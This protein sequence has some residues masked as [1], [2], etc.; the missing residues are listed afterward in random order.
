MSDSREIKFSGRSFCFTGG[1]ADLKR[2]AAERE[3]RARG[4][5][6]TDAVNDRLDYLVI[7]SI[8]S[9]GWKHGDYGSKIEKARAL[10]D[11]GAPRPSLVREREFLD[12][13]AAC[14]ILNEGLVDTQVFVANYRFVA[15]SLDSFDVAAVE[16]TLA[17]L[18]EEGYHVRASACDL[19]LTAGL[20][21]GEGATGHVVELR[22]VRQFPLGV[23][24]AALATPIERRF[25]GIQGVDGRLKWFTRMEGSASYI[26]LVREIPTRLRLE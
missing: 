22:L 11:S 15:A 8:P 19:R 12:A 9:H 24:I 14:A 20:F 1:M 17:A 2:S 25:E 13:L 21:T 7:G 16:S 6:T 5:L 23:D 18:A 10:R 26:R 3:T 4:G